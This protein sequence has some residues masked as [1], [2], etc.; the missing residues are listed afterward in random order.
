MSEEVVEEAVDESTTE[1]QT[2]ETVEN[3]GESAT[4]PEDA[5][6]EAPPKRKGGYQKR[7][8]KL[9]KEVYQLRA[10][11]E[12]PQTTQS[13]E[14]EPSV[15]DFEDYDKYQRA[16][17]SH[18]TKKELKEQSESSERSKRESEA[19]TVHENRQVAWDNHKEAIGDKYDD[20]DDILEHFAS[21]VTLSQIALDAILESDLGGDVVYHLGKNDAEAARIAKLSPA[22]QAIEIGK[23]EVMLASKPVK[24]ASKA[25]APIDPVKGKGAAGNS[26][27]SDSDDAETWIRKEAAR[28]RAKSG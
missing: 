13:Q 3:S 26:T 6:S 9:T 23:L 11:L 18:E 25:A 7:I 19:R 20:A 22:R 15:D 4:P 14:K 28:M 12:T 2:D 16:L 17:I 8:D 5:K 1:N 21:E 24:S 27:P 10:R